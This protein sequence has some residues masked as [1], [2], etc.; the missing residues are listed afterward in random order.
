MN[1]RVKE[2]ADN[3]KKV[4]A[5]EIAKALA[6]GKLNYKGGQFLHIVL[7]GEE[8]HFIDSENKDFVQL[9]PWPAVT[10]RGEE[11]PELLKE[12]S[13]FV[14]K[15]ELQIVVDS[16]QQLEARKAALVEKGRDLTEENEQ[17]AE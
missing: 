5:E 2:A 7:D 13:K 3:L 15:N 10:L 1:Q 11:F 4:Y 16:I 14:N 6:E 9:N 8:I 12:V 17:A